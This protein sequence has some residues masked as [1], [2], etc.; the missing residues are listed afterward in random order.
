LST[1]LCALLLMLLLQLMA[2]AE[3]L[4]QLISDKDVAAGLVYPSLE[5]RRRRQQQQQQQQS[6]K[7]QA[8]YFEPELHVQQVIS[9]QGPGLHIECKSL[10]LKGCTVRHRPAAHGAAGN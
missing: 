2:A 6:I 3:I 5:V 1:L 8:L 7:Q 9:V 10:L 4:P